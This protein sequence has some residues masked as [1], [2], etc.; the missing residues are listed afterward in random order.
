MPAAEIATN[1]ARARGLAS[2]IWRATSSLPEPG[3]PAIRMRL[4]A[5]ATLEM[6]LRS[7]C[8]A[9]DLPIRPLG[10]SVWARRRRFSRF[11]E[12]ASS[13]RSTTTTSRSDLNGFSMKS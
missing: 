2:W 1:S 4:L 5:G 8:A 13:A 10:V 3:G 9:T 6:V 7:A 12:A 11:R